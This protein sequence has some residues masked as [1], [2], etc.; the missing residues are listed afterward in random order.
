M[1]AMSQSAVAEAP[2]SL[3]SDRARIGHLLMRLVETRAPLTLSLA[4]SPRISATLLLALDFKSGH[5]ILDEPF[6]AQAVAQGALLALRGRVDGSTVEFQVP[7]RRFDMH[8]G[9]SALFAALP[10]TL[11][12]HE[13]RGSYRVQIPQDLYLPPTMFTSR[14]GAFR[15][16]LLD[17]SENGAGSLVTGST[18]QSNVDIATEFTKLIINQNGYQANSRVISTADTLLQTVI[19]MVQG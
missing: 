7:L 9:A 15:G 13:R 12:H 14:D 5:I 1:S 19:S 4:A 6:P 8:R 11:R 2:G 10:Q 18:E 17:I 3:I 16:R